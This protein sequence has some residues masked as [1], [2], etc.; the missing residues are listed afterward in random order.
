MATGGSMRAPG[1]LLATS[2]EELHKIQKDGVV[3][4]SEISRSHR[5]RLIRN[6]FLM[7]VVKGW[8]IITNPSLRESESTAWYASYWSF[9]RH[10]LNERFSNDY[11]LSPEASIKR[12]MGSTVIP[13][14]LIVVTKKKGVQTLSLLSGTSMLLYQEKRNFPVDR[15]NKDG[16]WILD[17]PA[18]LCKAQPSFFKNNPN[19]AEIALRMVRDPSQLLRI[20]LDKG[21]RAVAGRI[22]GAYMFLGEDRFAKRIINGMTAAGYKVRPANPFE[23]Q[24]PVLGGGR[25]T[26]PYMGRIETMWMSMRGDVADIFPAPPGIPADRGA[27]LKRIDEIFVNDAYNSLSIEGYKVTRELIERVRAGKWD[28]DKDENDKNQREA[29]AAKGYSLAFNSVKASIRKILKG[30]DASQIVAADHHEW[31]THMFSPSVQAG[32]LRPS[33]LAGYRNDQVYIRDSYH[34]PPPKE[35]IIDCMDALLKMIKNESHPGVCAVLGHLIFVFI[36]P[37]MDGNGRI[38]RFLM[39]ALLASGGYPWAVIRLERRRE[40]MTALEDASVKGRI[41][42]FARFI[43]DELKY[44]SRLKGR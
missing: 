6:G 12:H 41:S 36:H 32:I 15:V 1:E 8:L 22:A 5:E 11:C 25:I 37:Y 23:R 30:E 21:G 42:R 44:S 16:L 2:L 24:V 40:Y 18:A 28:P 43:K 17:L 27:Y 10:Y 14:Q 20:L 19:E 31:F 26:S 29:L 39:N 34:V 3:R 9:V 13:S 4:S 35:A 7:Q 33:D 38:G